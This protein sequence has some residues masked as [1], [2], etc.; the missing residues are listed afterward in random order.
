M[1]STNLKSKYQQTVLS[2]RIFIHDQYNTTTWEY[3]VALLKL[4]ERVK[5]SSKILPVCLPDVQCS[6]KTISNK[7]ISIDGCVKRVT[8]A[9][10]GMTEGNMDN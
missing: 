8:A 1:G 4:R 6:K 2:D 9:G 7:A 3:D 10:W 5:F